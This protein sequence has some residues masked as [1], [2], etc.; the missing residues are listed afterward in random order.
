[1]AVI[2]KPIYL[3][4]RGWKE[5]ERRR[6]KKSWRYR[7]FVF[8]FLM[9]WF[10]FVLVLHTL[11]FTPVLPPVGLDG[12]AVAVGTFITILLFAYMFRGGSKQLTKEIKP[13]TVYENGIAF[14][15]WHI[16]YG[17]KD[18]ISHRSF[19]FDEIKEVK[20][21]PH[22]KVSGLYNIYI[23]PKDED[24]GLLIR[25]FMV[26]DHEK[27]LKILEEKGVRVRREKNDGQWF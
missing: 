8:Y 24:H 2:S 14:T 4:K 26:S 19:T 15:E 9:F 18:I 25:H 5:A 12:Q 11:T 16:K 3:D 27:F 23:F 7:V 22:P 10:F 6:E 1:M 13:L 17:V 21:H 20:E